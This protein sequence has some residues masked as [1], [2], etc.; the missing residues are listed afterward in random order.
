MRIFLFYLIFE[1]LMKMKKNQFRSFNTVKLKSDFIRVALQFF[2]RAV[3]NFES[4][5]TR[6]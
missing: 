4:S 6:L 5:T 1:S 3:I 2:L